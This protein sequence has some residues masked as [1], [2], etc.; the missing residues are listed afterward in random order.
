MRFLLALALAL[1]ACGCGQKGPLYL[2]ENP[3]AGYKPPK[4]ET[5]Q[6]VPYPK[7]AA[8]DAEAA[9]K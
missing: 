7:D 9:E 2:R 8:R 6:P 3:P 1:A 4:S 5:Y